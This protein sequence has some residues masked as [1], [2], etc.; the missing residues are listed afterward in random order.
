MNILRIPSLLW[1]CADPTLRKYPKF[2]QH[3]QPESSVPEEE[4][5]LRELEKSVTGSESGRPRD[6]HWN[7]RER[8]NIINTQT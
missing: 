4:V 8:E 3:A 6:F 5:Y 1:V 7:R 2:I